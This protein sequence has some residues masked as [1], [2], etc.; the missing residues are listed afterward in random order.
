MH[1]QDAR[2]AT[3]H[4]EESLLG[5]AFHYST[6]VALSADGTYLAAGTSSGEV[7]LWRVADRQPV[8]AIQAHAGGVYSV[9]LSVDGELI[10]SGGVDGLVKLWSTSGACLAVFHGHTSI[11]QSV[12][13]G[14]AGRAR[15]ELPSSRH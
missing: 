2:L 3:A 8:L 5:E 4:L 9:A 12:A 11:I 14:S 6:S 1:A 13:I 10:V 7:R 15:P